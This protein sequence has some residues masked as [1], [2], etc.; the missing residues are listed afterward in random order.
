MIARLDIPYLVG[1]PRGRG[2]GREG[3][4]ELRY[5]LYRE[6]DVPGESIDRD[7]DIPVARFDRLVP[8]ICVVDVPRRA[9]RA[10]RVDIDAVIDPVPVVIRLVRP[11]RGESEHVVCRAPIDTEDRGQE[12]VRREGGAA[13]GPVVPSHP[14]GA[15]EIPVVL[16]VP[17][18]RLHEPLECGMRRVPH[19]IVRHR[20]GKHGDRHRVV[21]LEQAV[22]DGDDRLIEPRVPDRRHPCERGAVPDEPRIVDRVE[23]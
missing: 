23:E 18:R 13:H 3:R 17:H 20:E 19:G 16:L 12:A 5:G 6:A 11:R 1:R 14:L 7:Q 15:R 4:V 21:R 8:V 10:A 2:E 22:G 9:D